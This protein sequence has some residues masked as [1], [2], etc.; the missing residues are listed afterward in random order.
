M[1]LLAGVVPA[2]VPVLADAATPEQRP[3]I[4]FILSDDHTSQSWGIYGGV[5]ADYAR[6]E[7]I[8]RL[9]AE[10]GGARQLFLHQLHLGAQPRLYPDGTLQPPE[11]GLY[12]GTVA[13][14]EIRCHHSLGAVQCSRHHEVE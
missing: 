5:L 8:R 10:G 12:A 3:N 2:V 13:G 6:N 11:W 7:N 4:L 1:Y 9:A 14:L